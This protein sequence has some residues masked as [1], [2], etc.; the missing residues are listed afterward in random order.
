M[1]VLYL[2]GTLLCPMTVLWDPVCELIATHAR[3]LDREDFWQPFS[4]WL[5][6]AAAKTGEAVCVCV[7][8][9]VHVGVC[10][11]VGVVC[12]MRVCKC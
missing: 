3:G 2:M 1:P 11:C 8:V 5:T 7:H 4:H 12:G 9:L 6:V 10:F